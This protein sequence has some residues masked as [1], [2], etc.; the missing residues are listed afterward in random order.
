[1]LAFTHV[2][3]CRNKETGLFSIITHIKFQTQE[4]NW[5]IFL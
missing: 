1:M 5:N 4:I 3:A 2:I